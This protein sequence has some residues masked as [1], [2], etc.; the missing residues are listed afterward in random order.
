MEAQSLTFFSTLLTFP[1][2]VP[3]IFLGVVLIYWVLVILGALD[4]DVINMDW[5]IDLEMGDD[6]INFLNVIGVPGLPSSITLS[7]LIFTFWLICV[8]ST[9]YLAWLLP[10]GIGQIIAG[11]II[12]FVA[13]VL[14][15]QVTVW[16]VRPLRKVFSDQSHQHSAEHLVGKTCIISTASVDENFGQANY[17]DGGAGLI[18]N[19]RSTIPNDLKRGSRALMI[20]YDKHTHS[21]AVASLEEI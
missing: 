5:D 11:L 15:A 10:A 3:T 21:Y 4:I 20:E 17:E 9:Y 16:L 1:A 2:V 6:G 13:I 18:L 14:G 8:P 19:V 7:V 12:L